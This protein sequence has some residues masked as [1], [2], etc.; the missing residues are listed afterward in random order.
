MTSMRTSPHLLAGAVQCIA[1]DT[2][3]PYR[4]AELA[5]WDELNRSM[6]EHAPWCSLEEGAMVL[7]EEVDEL[8]EDVRSNQIGNARVEATQVGAMAARFIATFYEPTGPAR[9]RLRAALAELQDARVAVGPKNRSLASSHEA[10]GFL[11]RE[12]DALWSAVRFD[13]DARPAAGRVGAMALR[14]IAEITSTSTTV[15][16]SVQ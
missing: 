12:Y 4:H 5:I 1:G 14:F 8:W 6:A 15:R 9:N 3:S 13:D 7:A 2:E 11:K 10:F 16:G